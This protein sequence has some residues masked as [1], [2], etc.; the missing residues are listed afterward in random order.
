MLA[1]RV[2]LPFIVTVD[3]PADA[4]KLTWKFESGIVPGAAVFVSFVE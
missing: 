4:G 3:P 1:G 2:A